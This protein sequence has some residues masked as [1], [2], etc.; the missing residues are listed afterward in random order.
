MDSDLS[1]MKDYEKQ[2][3]VGLSVGKEEENKPSDNFDTRE[4]KISGGCGSFEESPDSF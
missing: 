3:D 2:P 4:T 1:E